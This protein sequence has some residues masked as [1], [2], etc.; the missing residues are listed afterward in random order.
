MIKRGS[1]AFVVK[2]QPEVPKPCLRLTVEQE[3][4]LASSPCSR[5]ELD[6]GYVEFLDP[7]DSNQ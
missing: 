1:T 4:E 5:D 2:G 3:I 6:E 7:D